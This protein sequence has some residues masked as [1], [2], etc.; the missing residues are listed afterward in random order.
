MDRTKRKYRPLD[1]SKG[2][3]FG[4]NLFYECLK[5]SE[6]VASAPPEST[7]CR[8]GNIMIDVGF[9]RMVIEDHS[10]VRLFEL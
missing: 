4:D 3:P 9:S 8:C 6:V 10:Q 5:C 1:P 2:Y 7:H